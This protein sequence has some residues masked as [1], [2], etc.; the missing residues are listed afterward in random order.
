MHVL[1]K[2]TGCLSSTT[3]D[4]DETHQQENTA[5]TNRIFSRLS[6]IQDKTIE[7]SIENKVNSIR[8]LK[9]IEQTIM[10]SER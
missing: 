5:S 1:R 2:L 9:D 3:C 8:D 10:I 6:V 7:K 4:N